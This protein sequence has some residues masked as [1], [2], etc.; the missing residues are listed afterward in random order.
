MIYDLDPFAQKKSN[1]E[2]PIWKNT[3]SRNISLYSFS[4]TKQTIKTEAFKLIFDAKC[5]HKIDLNNL[6]I[7]LDNKNG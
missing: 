2:I 3:Y 5:K 1:F 7:D 4:K 6:K